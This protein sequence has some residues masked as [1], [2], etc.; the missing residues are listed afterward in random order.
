[1]T[2]RILILIG[3]PGETSFT[4]SLA[5]AYAEGARTKGHEVRIMALADMQFDPNLAGGYNSIQA[6]EPGLVTFQEAVTWCNHLAIAHPLWWGM[7]PAKLKGL[8]DRA[9]LP[10]FAFKYLETSP[11]PAQLLKGR[12][13]EVLVAADTPVW[14]LYLVYRAGGY[15]ALKRQ[16][17]GFCGF[18]PVKFRTFAP[19]RG[20]SLEKRQSWLD[21][22][23]K[24]G[25][26]N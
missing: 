17:L 7:M 26:K 5:Q 18:S 9:F 8:F 25:A 23:R 10:G 6:L 1:M 15:R 16:I 12:S 22:A 3:H 24:L 20:S 4:A 11:F 14:W 19:V 13:A 2:K 21:E